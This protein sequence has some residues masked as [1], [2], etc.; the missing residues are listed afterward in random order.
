M[1]ARS[2]L[3]TGRQPIE[4]GR[5]AAFPDWL[6]AGEQG[7]DAQPLPVWRHGETARLTDAAVEE[8]RTRPPSRYNEGTL[9][10]AM[11]NAWRFVADGPWRDRLREAKGIGTPA[12]RAEVIHG[13]KAQEFLTLDGKHL[14]PT[15]RGL[16]LF[17]VPER[18]DPALVDP[19][20]AAQLKLLLD[21]VLIGSQEL[22]GARRCCMRAGAAHHR[23]AHG[24]GMDV[25]ALP[26]MSGVTP[27]LGK[28]ARG[29]TAGKELL[30]PTPAM[31][32]HVVS[33]ARQKGI[34]RPAGYAKSGAV[35]R[36]FL[37]QHAPGKG[38]AGK[39][40]VL[41]AAT[42]PVVDEPSP[43]PDAERPGTAV[44]GGQA[45]SPPRNR[46][47]RGLAA[48]TRKTGP[49]GHRTT[50]S[51]GVQDRSCAGSGADV[52]PE[53]DGTPLRIPSATRGPPGSS[54]HGTEPVDGMHHRK[55][56]SIRSRECGWV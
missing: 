36:S 2:Y 19:G 25:Q 7:E 38:R 48:S 14:V 34:A 27:L 42:W 53:A 31:K 8:K 37:G 54:A 17:G 15:E 12:T 4:A 44:S 32:R 55:S 56:R 28:T 10:A 46:K 1:A 49:A 23:P 40:A 30:P 18:A 47:E 13:L 9:V 6:P 43:Q 22:A 52:R 29:G 26:P 5:R 51:P 45:S 21:E 50:P 33:L 3:A 24:R 41:A 20:V 16:A 35:C 39:S 11:Q